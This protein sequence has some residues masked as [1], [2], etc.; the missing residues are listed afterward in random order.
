[1]KPNLWRFAFMF[2][3]ILLTANCLAQKV[4]VSLQAP[5]STNDD[6]TA[7]RFSKSLADEI[8][9][10]GKFYLW[11]GKYYDLPPN[12]MRIMVRSIQVEL[13]SGAALGSAIF[14]DAERPSVKDPGYYRVV[15]EQLWMIPK[16]DSVADQTR[17]F[18][19]EVDRAL[20]R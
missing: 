11:T 5:A 15:S 2:G 13:R 17:G 10:S 3:A 9:L 7:L 14:V 20:E 6:Q 18:L 8:Q 4:P 12:G 19:A 16:D 1:M